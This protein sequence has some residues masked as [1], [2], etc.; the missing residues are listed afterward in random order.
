MSVLVRVA[1]AVKGY[2]DQSNFYKGKHVMVQLQVSEVLSTIMVRHGSMQ[3]D[4]AQEKELRVNV[5]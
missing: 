4:T 2:S 1:I 5:S 3:T